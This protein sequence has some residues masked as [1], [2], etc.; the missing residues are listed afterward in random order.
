[1]NLE[2]LTDSEILTLKYNLTDVICETFH[3]FAKE[4]PLQFN[5]VDWQDSFSYWR[6]HRPAI[7]AINKI[8]EKLIDYDKTDTSTYISD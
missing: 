4:E 3:F 6:F 8:V 1:M 2:D 7:I 5:E